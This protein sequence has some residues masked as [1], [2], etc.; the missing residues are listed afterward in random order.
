MQFA[1]ARR[2][3]KAC[4]YD[5]PIGYYFAWE[6]IQASLLKKYADWLRSGALRSLQHAR[7]DQK[8][9]EMQL[10]DLTLVPSTFVEK[11]IRMFH[12]NKAIAKAPYGVDLDF[13]TPGPQKEKNEVLRF[14]YAG[15]I[16]IRKGIPGLIEAWEKAAVPNASLELVGLWQFAEGRRYLLP[17]NVRVLPPCSSFELRERY[18]NADVFV[19]PSFFEG[20]GLVLLEAMACGLPAIAS[21]STVGPE[22]LNDAS[23][24]IVPTG[25][26][27]ALVESLRW[28][29]NHR[30]VLPVLSSAA[31]SRAEEFTWERYRR[32][33][34]KAVASLV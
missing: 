23:G 21:D 6:E 17:R 18:R 19:F 12:P 9:Q 11:T 34:D 22:V 32:C 16:S 4:I 14:I 33:V 28:Y 5:M 25:D 13:W 27:E 29:H 15:Q 10:A 8:R 3:G 7:R 2:R 1:E 24:H 30:E 20:F 31:R 26:E